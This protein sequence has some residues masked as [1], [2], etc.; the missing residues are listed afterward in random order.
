MSM[1]N[2]KDLCYPCK[3]DEENEIDTGMWDKKIAENHLETELGWR[4]TPQMRHGYKVKEIWERLIDAHLEIKNLQTHIYELEE[5]ISN[6]YADD[7]KR[8]IRQ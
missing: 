3:R 1:L 2:C 4:W 5:K 8:E 7:F 6:I